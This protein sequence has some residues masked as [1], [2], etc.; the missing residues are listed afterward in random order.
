MVSCAR[1]PG[2]ICKGS[3]N[4]CGAANIFPGPENARY[5]SAKI[6]TLFFLVLIKSINQNRFVLFFFVF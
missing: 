1:Y 3:W 5:L 4:L 6:N 2:Q